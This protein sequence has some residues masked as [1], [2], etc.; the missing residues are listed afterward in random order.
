[1]TI[2]EYLQELDETISSTPEVVQVDILR[3]SVLDTG[4]EI[5]AVYRYKLFMSDGSLLELT[6]RLIEISGQLSRTKYRFHWQDGKGEI[7][8]RW[9]NAPHHSEVESFPNHLHDGSESHVVSHDMIAG[10]EI[11]NRVISAITGIL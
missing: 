3:R 7:I 2:T 10:N 11:V 1:M 4:M 6:E 8:K 9:D 5:V